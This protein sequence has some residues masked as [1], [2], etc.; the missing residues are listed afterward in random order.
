MLINT[1]QK[2]KSMLINQMIGNLYPSVTTFRGRG[3]ENKQDTGM[4]KRFMAGENNRER[5]QE[6]E[7]GTWGPRFER[8]VLRPCTMTYT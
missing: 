2:I 3:R 7:Q 1:N 4:Q 6:S 8:E 5:K